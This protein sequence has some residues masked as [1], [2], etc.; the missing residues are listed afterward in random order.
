MKRRHGAR[1][2]TT[3][4]RGQTAALYEVESLSQLLDEARNLQEI[5][6]VVRV[7]H[8]H[9][10]PARCGYSTHE[11]V[12]IA[13]LAHGNH[14]SSQPLGDCL[15]AVRASVVGNDHLT[16]DPGIAQRSL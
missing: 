3:S 2:H 12:A 9:E 8:D 16:A 7:S 11:R 6:A 14:P 15:G 10:A 5:V 13:P 1:H 4:P